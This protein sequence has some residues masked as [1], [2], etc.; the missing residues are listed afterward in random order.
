MNQARSIAI[1]ASERAQ[2]RGL[3]GTALPPAAHPRWLA[4]LVAVYCV[5]GLG[6]VIAAT[7][8]FYPFFTAMQLPYAPFGLDPA[9]S[10]FSLWVAICVA[11]ASQRTQG[12]GQ[13]PFVSSIAPIMAAGL[14]GGPAA[15][16]WVALLGTV[17]IR[18]IRDGTPWSDLLAG[19]AA[20]CLAAT[21]GAVVMLGVRVTPIDPIQLRDLGAILV[22]TAAAVTVDQGLGLALWSARTG[23]HTNEAFAIVSRVDWAVAA[24]SEACIAWMAALVYFQ[25]LWW[26]PVLIVVANLAAS[27]SMAHHQSSWRLRHSEKTGLPTRYVFDELWRDLPRGHGPQQPRC[28][29]YLD[30]DGFKQVNDDHGHKTGDDVLLEVGSRLRAA[31][32]RD[33]FIAHLHGDEFLAL[34]TGVADQAAAEKV[35]DRLRQL[36]DPRIEHPLRGSLHVSATAGTCLLPP[37]PELKPARDEGGRLQAKDDL[38]KDELDGF[39]K[40]ADEEMNRRK[41]R[42]N[43]RGGQDRRAVADSEPELRESAPS[44]GMAPR[45]DSQSRAPNGP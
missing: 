7:A 31:I 22:G 39:M 3:M 18:A 10:G 25:G 19:Y 13:V 20:R 45:S 37:L 43:R 27:R 2:P 30:L 32:T 12:T 11:T 5:A 35:I 8:T 17:P 21:V 38:A 4:T 34:A 15:A 41:D 16:V 33:L 26:A 9:L 40:V 28:L 36:I 44:D 42:S 14:L 24:G 23:R 29:L 6:A 1:T